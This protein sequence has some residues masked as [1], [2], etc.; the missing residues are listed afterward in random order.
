[1]PKFDLF[2]NAGGEPPKKLQA[3]LKDYFS[4]KDFEKLHKFGG[5]IQISLT[6][7]FTDRTQQTDNLKIDGKFIN[8]LKK[9]PST[10]NEKLTVLT[11]KQLL[12]VALLL[13][14]SIATKASV[15]EVKKVLVDYL[16][17]EK[18]WK[19]ISGSTITSKEG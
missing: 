19:N 6:A 13:G 9:T 14:V 10:V 12:E 1:M 11:K 3:V 7:P 16:T 17:S 15:K 8:N 2:I 4:D 5:R 18:T